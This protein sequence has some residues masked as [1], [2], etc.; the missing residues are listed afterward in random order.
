[1]KHQMEGLTEELELEKKKEN[2]SLSSFWERGL[3]LE[4][5]GLERNI[6]S[7]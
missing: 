2:P 5:F 1:M 3:V 7:G 4:V 6:M